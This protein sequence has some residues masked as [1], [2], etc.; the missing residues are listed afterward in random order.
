MIGVMPEEPAFYP[1]M[2]AREYL[3]DFVAPLFGIQAGAAARRSAELLEL[4]GLSEAGD[5][6]VGGFSRGMRQRLGLAQALVH[7]PKVLLLD[8]PVSAL[9]PAGRREV[10]DLIESLRGEITILFSTHILDDVERHCDRIGIINKGRMVVQDERDTLLQR[11]AAPLIEV[12]ASNGFGNWPEQMR[13]MSWVENITLNG[14]VARLL[15][16]D[17]NAARSPLLAS[18]AESS[19]SV[20]RFEIVHPSLEDVF[21]RLTEKA[22]L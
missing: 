9:D 17:V 18:L 8:E 3:R 7:Q 16:T 22:N 11:Y 19:L 14:K 6:R 1:W 13:Q 21:L 2:T 15:V 10:L 12:E 5:R 4:V 20:R